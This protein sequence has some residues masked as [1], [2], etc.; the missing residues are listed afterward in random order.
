MEENLH[1]D[2]DKMKNTNA[3]EPTIG[4]GSSVSKPMDR[5][6]NYGNS[7]DLLAGDDGPQK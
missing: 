5:K 4:S 3:C 2:F 7:K 1:P 6:V